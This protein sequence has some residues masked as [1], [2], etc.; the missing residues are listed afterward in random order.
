MIGDLAKSPDVN[1]H[2]MS[3]TSFDLG[4]EL[5]THIQS[6]QDGVIFLELERQIK[7]VQH[8]I[9]LVSLDLHFDCFHAKVS[10]DDVFA[11]ELEEAFSYLLDE[12]EGF[13]F[14]ETSWAGL[15]Q[16]LAQSQ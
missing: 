1:C 4:S 2:I 11:M 6:L 15:S 10:M 16:V 9:Q 12:D 3:Q 13:F 14:S 7:V 8:R 5:P